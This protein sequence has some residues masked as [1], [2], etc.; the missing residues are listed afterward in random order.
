MTRGKQKYY[1]KKGKHGL[2]ELRQIRF[3]DL[4]YEHPHDVCAIARSKKEMNRMR[5]KFNLY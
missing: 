3:R 4:K 5:R 1:V 2:Y